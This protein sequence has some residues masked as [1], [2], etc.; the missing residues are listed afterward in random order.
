M[1][2]NT[3]PNAQDLGFIMKLRKGLGLN[4][5]M[6]TVK[7]FQADYNTRNAIGRQFLHIDLFDIDISLE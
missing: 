2:C 7:K 3:Y 1:C 6:Y 5:H 4:A